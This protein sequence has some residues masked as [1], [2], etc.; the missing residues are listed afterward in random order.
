MFPV[1]SIIFKDPMTKTFKYFPLLFLCLNTLTYGMN[2]DIEALKEKSSRALHQQ[3]SN[4]DQTKDIQERTMTTNPC[5]NFIFD[6]GDITER[7]I[8]ESN[9]ETFKNLSLVST[10]FY[11]I[12]NTAQKHRPAV[13]LKDI[14]D[15]S[16]FE[17]Y[18]KKGELAK[19]ITHIKNFRILGDFGITQRYNH[20]FL[21]LSLLENLEILEILDINPSLDSPILGTEA[22]KHFLP[23]SNVLQKLK[24]ILLQ[25]TI[26]QDGAPEIKWID[27]IKVINFFKFIL[28][29][30]KNLEWIKLG[31]SVQ[32]FYNIQFTRI[33]N[34]SSPSVETQVGYPVPFFRMIKMIEKQSE[35]SQFQLECPIELISFTIAN[36]S[37]H[38]KQ[39]IKMQDQ[40][41]GSLLDELVQEFDRKSTATLKITYDSETKL[42]RTLIFK[43]KSNTPPSSNN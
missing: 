41:Y 13:V 15:P 31:P 14:S 27:D 18:I 28:S 22:A 6:N 30:A 4:E 5:S 26:N 17:K 34:D 38:E 37:N 32:S 25:P 12:T 43:K 2:G 8:L 33:E 23:E 39:F 16:F 7:I 24:T 21:T 40:G 42:P 20:P 36:A 35:Q 19:N 3:P 10:L 9:S 29:K 11:T 1:R